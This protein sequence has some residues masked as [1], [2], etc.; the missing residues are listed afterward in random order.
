M[1][2]EPACPG[3]Y[4]SSKVAHLVDWPHLGYISI[5]CWPRDVSLQPQIRAWTT[6]PILSLPNS[7]PLPLLGVG[8]VSPG[9]LKPSV[10]ECCLCFPV[11]TRTNPCLPPYSTLT[12]YQRSN[13]T[14]VQLGEQTPP[15]GLLPGTWLRSYS[16][17]RQHNS[18]RLDK[19]SQK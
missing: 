10:S 3:P 6:V 4:D 12:I 7:T 15:W 19:D 11:A 13:T 17:E 18:K 8:A 5:Q 1:P 14:Q 2:T 9:K 16:Q